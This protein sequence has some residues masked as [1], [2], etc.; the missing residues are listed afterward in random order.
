[1]RLGMA[2]AIHS[3]IWFTAPY[4]KSVIKRQMR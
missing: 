3:G 4:G 1:V 2:S